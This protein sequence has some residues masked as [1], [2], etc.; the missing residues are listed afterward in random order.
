MHK[1][2]KSKKIVF[3]VALANHNAKVYFQTEPMLT[4]LQAQYGTIL[5]CDI[6]YIL[7][8]YVFL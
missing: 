6:L 3:I 2:G 5:F 1:I 8:L 4:F 7:Y